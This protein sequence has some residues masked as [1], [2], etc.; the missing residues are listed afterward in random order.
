MH[1]KEEGQA[2]T[3]ILSVPNRFVTRYKDYHGDGQARIGTIAYLVKERHVHFPQTYL[4]C[5]LHRVQYLEIQHGGGR[6]QRIPIGRIAH[7]FQEVDGGQEPYWLFIPRKSKK[8][9]SE[10]FYEKNSHL[11]NHQYTMP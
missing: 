6:I 7:D 8:K 5:A 1:R 2:E 3:R 9:R 10:F 4:T 11:I